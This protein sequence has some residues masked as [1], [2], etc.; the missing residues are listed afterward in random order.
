MVFDFIQNHFAFE[1]ILDKFAIFTPKMSLP[2]KVIS[3]VYL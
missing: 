1:M 2:V 3:T